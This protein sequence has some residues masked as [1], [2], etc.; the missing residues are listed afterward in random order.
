MMIKQYVFY[1][2]IVGL[3]SIPLRSNGQYDAYGG[4]LDVKAPAS[5]FFYVTK[6]GDRYTLVTPEGH[7]Y[8]AMGINHMSTYNKEAYTH[9]GD[10]QNEARVIEKFKND[11][12]Y[13][14]MNNAGG[15]CPEIIKDKMPFFVTLALTT[16]A[17]WLPSS[18]FDF[19]DVFSPAFIEKTKEY[20]IRECKKYKDNQYLIG[21][22]WTD[23]PRWDVVISR[24]RHLKDWVSYLRNLDGDAPGKQEYV[25]FLER[26]YK[27]IEAF[28]QAYGLHFASFEKIK[29]ARFDHIDFHQEYVIAD[30]TEFLGV[31]AD[32]LYKLASETIKAHDPNHLILGEKYIAG[33]HP[34][35]VLLA[36]AKYVD[37]ISIQPGPEKGPGPGPGKE[38][39]LFNK[40]QFDHIHQLTGKPVIVC[41]HSI[42]FYTKAQP[43]TLWHQCK[44][45]EQ[46]G[47]VTSQYILDCANQQYMIGY[48]HCMYLSAY[49]PQ[50]GLLKQGLLDENGEMHQPLCSLIKQANEEALKVVK[51]D[52]MDR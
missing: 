44:N 52:L 31:I 21:Y 34:D 51:K 45:Q 25:R 9:V 30:D 41:D 11:L 40:S 46:A 18:R 10:F 49:D 36:A 43:G 39:S 42:S 26:K 13:L 2:L 37:V 7:G 15:D 50:R 4:W 27:T 23:T 35:P 20:I 22:Y 8:Y 1:L 28:N 5:G 12:N 47:A 24:N 14:S 3:L 17:H 33:D 48:N 32:H 16:N 6:K 29:D 38:E 19:Q